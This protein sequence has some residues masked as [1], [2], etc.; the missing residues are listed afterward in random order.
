MKNKTKKINPRM[1]YWV[2]FALYAVAAVIFALVDGSGDVDRHMHFLMIFFIA[3]NVFDSRMDIMDIKQ[4][5]EH[6]PEAID[7]DYKPVE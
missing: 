6:K 2:A 4:K 7:A 3:Y 5:L 1:L